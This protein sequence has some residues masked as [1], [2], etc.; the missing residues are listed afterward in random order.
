VNPLDDLRV[1]IDT[2]GWAV[3]NV[4]SADPSE[5]FSY[6]VGLTAHDH[7][8]FVM[9]GLPPEVGQEFLN[10]AGEIVVREGGRFTA[11]VPTSELAD[12][13]PLPVLEVEDKAGLT[14]VEALY[15]QVS[16]L[17]IVWTDSAGRLPWDAG[18]NNPPGS[19]P[20]LGRP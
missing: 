6:T 3:R 17:Q 5:C 15:G 18:Y 16:A 1:K 9:T 2:F 12:G 11:G 10:L 14:A 19:Q 13:P 4:V 20:L 8:E 7:P